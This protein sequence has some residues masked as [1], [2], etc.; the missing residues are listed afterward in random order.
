MAA[1]AALGFGDGT[2]VQDLKST[3]GAASTPSAPA[4]VCLGAEANDPL[5]NCTVDSTRALVPAP[6]VARDD[7]SE[8]Y[9]KK[10]RTGT[11]SP[12]VKA[13]TFGDPKG[14]SVVSRG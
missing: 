14:P 6:A 13:C 12:E 2:S 9:D 4:G 11:L 8:I 10:C 5:A 1:V 3:V 7:I